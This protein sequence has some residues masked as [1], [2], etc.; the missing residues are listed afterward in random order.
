MNPV[1][2]GAYAQSMQQ[3][4]TYQAARAVAKA[5]ES[6]FA[7]HRAEARQNGPEAALAPAPPAHVIEAILDAAFWA[8]LR[9]E[10]G[11]SPKISLAYLSPE[12][13]GKPLVFEHRFPLTPTILAKL[14]PGVERPGIHLGVWY[15]ADHLYIWGTTQEVMSY[16]FVVDVSEPGLLVV[17]HRRGDGFGKFANVAVL[18]GDQ[19]K[20][21][22]E[23]SAS[24]PDCPGLLKPLLNLSAPFSGDSTVNVLVQLAVSMRAHQRGGTLLVVPAEATTWQD[25]IIKPILYSVSPA[26]SN[27]SGLMQQPDDE[28]KKGPWLA[29]VRQ[30][31][32][33]LAGLTAIDGATIIND[34]HELLAFGTKIGRAYGHDPVEQMMITEPI[35]GNEGRVIHPSQNGGTRHLSA[36]QFVYDQRDAL[37]L[38]AS[39]DGRFTVF[40]WSSCEE[41]VHAHRIDSLLL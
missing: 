28:K 13:A 2:P 31:V 5:V 32:G 17:K 34:R 26:F 22:N 15:E 24:L 27:L 40:S 19:V 25:S 35:V 4:S 14:A 33:A 23:E 18:K 38:V 36:A 7:Q 1:A 41:M 16:G 6:H 30:E 11:Q 9:K 20:L 37:A 21:I 3:E 39:Q 12:M 8:S 29:A 10:E